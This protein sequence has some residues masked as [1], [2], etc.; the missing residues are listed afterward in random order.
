MKPLKSSRLNRQAS[1]SGKARQQ[2]E[3]KLSST[4]KAM[5]DA[6]QA[7]FGDIQTM[8]MCGSC[9]LKTRSGSRLGRFAKWN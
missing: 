8:Q 7:E 4:V 6:L 9:K 3:S 5:E 2:Y 1:K